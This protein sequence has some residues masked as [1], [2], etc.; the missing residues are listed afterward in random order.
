MSQLNDQ[1]IGQCAAAA[2]R[3]GLPDGVKV[4]MIAQAQ[5]YLASFEIAENSDINQ[6]IETTS[7]PTLIK[8]TTSALLSSP[9][10]NALLE[11]LC[12]SI[13]GEPIPT[14][15]DI[16]TR[17]SYLQLIGQVVAKK[18]AALLKKTSDAIVGLLVDLYYAA[19][20]P[21][22]CEM[23]SQLSASELMMVDGDSMLIE[24]FC[25]MHV[26]WNMM[27]SLHVSQLVHN[28]LQGLLDRGARMQVVF[29]KCHEW[30]YDD[31]PQKRLI[32]E[33][34]KRLLL[35]RAS[36]E[37]APFAAFEFAS[38]YCPE[39]QNHVRTYKPEFII[40]NDGE[41]MWPVNAADAENFV[42]VLGS[43]TVGPAAAR[44]LHRLV[45]TLVS[46]R[47]YVVYSSR[48]VLKDNGIMVF[49]IQAHSSNFIPFEAI[50]PKIA[51]ISQAVDSEHVHLV[52]AKPVD[53]LNTGANRQSVTAM[54]IADLHKEGT[55]SDE[56]K[57]ILKVVLVASIAMQDLDVTVR[58]QAVAPN[59]AIAAVLNRFSAAAVKY[60]VGMSAFKGR[61]YDLIDGH[62]IAA[63][64][65]LLSESAVSSLVE[66]D[67]CATINEL[68]QAATAT[69][70][71][72][73]NAPI[74][75]LPAVEIVA[76]RPNRVPKLVQ[77]PLIDDLMATFNV[78]PSEAKAE[79]HE[80]VGK[81]QMD[82]CQGWKYSH[83]FA[84][85]NDVITEKEM[86]KRE[87]VKNADKMQK[88][89]IDS[90]M[91]IA[92]SMKVQPSAVCNRVSKGTAT[93]GERSADVQLTNGLNTIAKRVN[94][95]LDSL[96]RLIKRLD[97]KNWIQSAE[98]LNAKAKSFTLA[99]GRVENDVFSRVSQKSDEFVKYFREFLKDRNEVQPARLVLGKEKGKE[100]K[101]VQQNRDKVQAEIT[102][103]LRTSPVVKVDVKKIKIET[104]GSCTY[105]HILKSYSKLYALLK[106]MTRWSRAW[107]EVKA[108][109]IAKLSANLITH[110][111]VW[112]L[113]WST[114]IGLWQA[115][116]DVL[117]QLEREGVPLDAK[118]RSA[119][120][121]AVR[122]LDVP[123]D[124]ADLVD[125]KLQEFEGN[126]TLFNLS[127]DIQ[128]MKSLEMPGLTVERFQ[129]RKM[130]HL[131]PRSVPTTSDQRVNFNPDMWQRELMDVVD[132]RGSAVVCAPTSSGK[133]F[134]S[135]YCMESVFAAPLNK[136]TKEED[137][138]VV[139]YVAPTR[140]L[141]NQA[142]AE[143]Y[144]R[145]SKQG[146]RK[147]GVSVFGSLGGKDFV[148][149]PF[150]CQA[151]VTLPEVLET[152]LLS[153]HHQEWLKRVKYFIF[154]EIHS[155]ES[156]GNGAVWERLLS[157]VRA[158]F[159]ALSATL[160]KAE[161]L[162]GWLRRS[163]TQLKTLQNEAGR[164]YNVALVPEKEHIARWSDIEKFA[165]YPSNVK[166]LSDVRIT[167]DSEIN[168]EDIVPYHPL[169]SVEYEAL[170][171]KG[172][173]PPDTS[174]VPHE[175]LDLYNRIA[176][177]SK[178]LRHGPLKGNVLVQRMKAAIGSL[179]PERY[180][181]GMLAIKQVAARAWEAK[182]KSTII[183]WTKMTSRAGCAELGI[184]VSSV[185]NLDEVMAQVSIVARSVIASFSTVVT[186]KEAELQATAQRGECPQPDTF[187]F[188][189]TGIL[190][191]VRTIMKRKLHPALVF[192]FDQEEIEA[193]VD[194]LVTTLEEAEEAYRSSPGFQNY[195][196]DMGLRRENA[197][198]HNRS[199]KTQG[200]SKEKKKND[201]GSVTVTEKDM[202]DNAEIDLSQYNIPEILP[203]FR[204]VDSLIEDT[205]VADE[206]NSRYIDEK[207]LLVRAMRRGIGMHHAGIPG[208]MRGAVERMFRL[209]QLPVVFATQGL[210]LG[211]HSPCRT[212]VLA[213]DNLGLN[214]TQYRQMAGRAGR[215]GLDFLGHVIFFGI[216]VKKMNRLH[217][218]DMTNLK[219]HSIMDPITNL[220]LLQLYA[221]PQKKSKEWRAS[222]AT[223]AKCGAV[224]PLF[225]YGRQKSQ[226]YQVDH[227]RIMR[228]LYSHFAFQG[229]DFDP[230]AETY[231]PSSVGHLA[232]V[233]LNIR[234]T[235]NTGN[236]S[237]VLV[238]LLMSTAF[239]SAFKAVRG[240]DADIA[241]KSNEDVALLVLSYI[242]S[243][244]NKLNISLEIHRGCLRDPLTS[245]L[246][247][248]D[249]NH[250]VYLRE[251]PRRLQLAIDELA[252]RVLVVYSH[253][254]REMGLNL[255]PELAK[256]AF[257][258]PFGLIGADGVQLPTAPT[259]SKPSVAKLHEALMVTSAN[260]ASRHPFLALCG[261]GDR[262]VST[263]DLVQSTRPGVFFDI[264]DIP[265]LDFADLHRHDGSR[266]LMNAC[267]YD[268]LRCGSQQRRSNFL[269]LRLM[270]FNG[271][272]QTNSWGTLNEI[273]IALG[274]LSEGL[275][276]IAPVDTRGATV[277]YD[278]SIAAVLA[279]CEKSI[280]R[281]PHL[282]NRKYV[283]SE[284]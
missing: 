92:D 47:V 204:L 71:D 33:V 60:F 214:V 55:L 216:S 225:V 188:V 247:K 145:Y 264:S 127:V 257:D 85:F 202:N 199:I 17:D 35:T 228:H 183:E 59:A 161:E 187:D 243:R 42:G 25:N 83:N 121:T 230:N 50:A 9:H 155:L 126:H 10:V 169:S 223:Y 142:V 101:V 249:R 218:S 68:Y 99:E 110:E 48:Q 251:L 143:I 133:T 206:V 151:L 80:K 21:E 260:V 94:I 4:D 63:L 124:Y 168:V 3:L 258:L 282:D 14:I 138:N 246:E 31:V 120:R 160:G 236:G 175:S 238:A 75:G 165:F 272:S 152:I 117:S 224:E 213:G 49:T 235:S 84:E 77:N 219:G 284:M 181:H 86:K 105:Y 194:T 153:P 13:I 274:S 82:D 39:F 154:D 149:D 67:L 28:F 52:A 64:S 266:V 271:L 108:D 232:S 88:K 231:E 208:K 16:K 277:K 245:Y 242:L 283:V 150:T 164:P 262:Y 144:G 201:D 203:E 72:I 30:F 226:N 19:V 62:L 215:R 176:Y 139:V 40:V 141:I 53:A 114:A 135:Y 95:E 104:L 37:N 198:K 217:T 20:K 166:P 237:L 56:E 263:E 109:W 241:R 255:S 103:F 26:D 191:L 184:D 273:F 276:E 197:E 97:E 244:A 79:P 131:L 132:S 44:A 38:F 210:A 76:P 179:F 209:K 200:S 70:D 58:Q 81:G 185:E 27:Q 73:T 15:A 178:A 34:I 156:S 125:K 23:F 24:A 270:Y 45:I 129:L 171:A 220:R 116:Q 269:R 118:D 93:V 122:D 205:D 159:V 212:V 2:S 137:I 196:A 252:N 147:P 259:A 90:I 8:Y 158:P 174:I 100:G 66:S 7:K 148:L 130:G 167:Q 162:V 107:R 192:N 186:A 177:A 22:V 74:A 96:E 46:L 91:K 211:I 102:N 280:Q 18:D 253:V 275:A 115:V 61:D 128:P 106:I 261:A 12:T 140:A 119:L 221:T 163:Q 51:E 229:L 157:M 254:A 189:Q 239:A 146:D 113:D 172:E 136:N 43:G 170:L 11:K 112:D 134:I 195:V 173:F 248:Q 233:M 182:L 190:R 1:F 123:N 36:Q 250:S 87:E 278:D 234:N 279:V 240:N 111:Q 267:M 265:T 65:K 222:I 193:L 227:L 256:Q 78:P 207:S 268:Y 89:Y 57:A 32:R 69:K 180:F 41:Q 5:T 6:E 281:R 98:E 54:A 29:F